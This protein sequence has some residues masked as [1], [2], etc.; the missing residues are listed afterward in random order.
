MKRDRERMKGDRARARNAMVTGDERNFLARD[1]GPVRKFVRDYVDARRTVAEFFLPI[2]LVI[3]LTSFV[4]I[5]QAQVF[6]TLLMLV[7]MV[8]VVFDLILLR[9]RVK[10]ELQARFPGDDGRGHT[11]YAISR[12][13]QI[14]KLRMPKPTVKPGD[15]V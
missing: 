1:R 14:R 15:T 7:T 10:R 5:A 9:S 6:S 12:A 3:L 8:M 11:L 4:N 13:T 2:V